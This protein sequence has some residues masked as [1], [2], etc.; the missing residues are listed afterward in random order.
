MPH[1]CSEA[2]VGCAIAVLHYTALAFAGTITSAVISILDGDTIEVLRNNRTGRI[3]LPQSQRH[4]K[5]QR[6]PLNRKNG[7]THILACYFAS[8][9]NHKI[10]AASPTKMATKIPGMIATSMRTS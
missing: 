9:G 4:P 2:L 6:D 5:E 1:Y 8:Y 3:H 10:R 7:E